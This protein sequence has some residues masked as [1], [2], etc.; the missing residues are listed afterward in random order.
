MRFTLIAALSIL[1]SASAEVLSLTP[2]NIGSVTG[3]A[4]FVKFFAPWCGHC[5]SMAGDWKQLAEE[6][7]GTNDVVIAEA[8][9]TSDEIGSICKDNGVQGFPTLK[10]GNISNLSDYAGGRGFEELNEFA[11]ENLKPSCSPFNLELCEGDEKAKLEKIMAMSDSE[12]TAIL[13]GV[14]KVIA[15]EDKKLE[16]EVEKLSE[17][18]DEMSEDFEAQQEKKK[19]A[20]D[21]KLISTIHKMKAPPKPDDDDDDDDD[22]VMD[23]DDDMMDDDDDDDMIQYEY[24]DDDEYQ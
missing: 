17:K 18:Y 16:A 9:C 5:K 3:K 13:A 6:W 1:S 11:K 12:I 8:D 4:V 23:D 7:E 15:E 22:D 24:H 14:D 20:L 2:E 21:Y 10:Y 19:E